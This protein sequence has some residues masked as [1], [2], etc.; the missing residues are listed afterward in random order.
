MFLNKKSLLRLV[1]YKNTTRQGG[2]FYNAKK[3]ALAEPYYLHK[4]ISNF[5]VLQ[6]FPTMCATLCEGF[7]KSGTPPTATNTSWK[8]IP[9]LSPIFYIM[10]IIIKQKNQ[11]TIIKLFCWI[12]MCATLCKIAV[13]K[14]LNHS[15]S[16]KART[17]N[18]ICKIPQ[19]FCKW[20][21]K[22]AE[23]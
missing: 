2:D 13:I 15:A 5:F 10:W 20:C 19:G 7:G 23:P 9:W 6:N 18:I 1:I 22:G 4:K 3:P 8:I 16:P 14:S 21:F 11:K 17:K 12:I